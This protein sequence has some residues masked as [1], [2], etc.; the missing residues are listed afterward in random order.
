M[1]FT[2]GFLGALIYG[3]LIWCAVMV[4]ILLVMLGR[5]AIKGKL[6]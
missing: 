1:T 5:D 4:L 6:W 3:S 2:S